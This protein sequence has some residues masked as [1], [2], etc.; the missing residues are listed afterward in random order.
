MRGSAYNELI[1]IY[2]YKLRNIYGKESH[3]NNLKEKLK[4]Y[5]CCYGRRIIK[6]T[7]VLLLLKYSYMI[8]I[9][10][11]IFKHIKLRKRNLIRMNVILDL[12]LLI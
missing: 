9:Y 8:N 5:C 11:S 6:L 3:N 2:V 7:S 12:K 4:L 1:K 10:I